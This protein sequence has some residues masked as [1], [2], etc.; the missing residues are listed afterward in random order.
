[1]FEKIKAL[2]RCDLLILKISVAWGIWLVFGLAVWL[3]FPLSSDPTSHGYESLHV[4]AW[5]ITAQLPF[6]FFLLY[7]AFQSWQRISGDFQFLSCSVLILTIGAVGA[8]VW[9]FSSW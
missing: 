5:V 7:T 9:Y 1:M 4:L 8:L 3:L 6:S 2:N